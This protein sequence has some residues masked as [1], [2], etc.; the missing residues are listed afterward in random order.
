MLK[1]KATVELECMEEG[2]LARILRGDGEK[3]I[4][5]GEVTFIFG[6]RGIDWICL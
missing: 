4:K 3:E 6:S 5:I 1:D 2:Y